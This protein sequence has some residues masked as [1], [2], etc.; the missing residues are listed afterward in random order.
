MKS[1]VKKLTLVFFV[2]AGPNLSLAHTCNTFTA[3][4]PIINFE[5]MDKQHCE[6]NLDWYAI[7]VVGAFPNVCE[8]ITSKRVVPN[9][10][11][12]L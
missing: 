7:N 11:D 2:L 8:P 5:L 4:C 6:T 10:G 1:F 3:T 9:L 12:I